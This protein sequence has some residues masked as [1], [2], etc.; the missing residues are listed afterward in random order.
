MRRY[1]FNKQLTYSLIFLLVVSLGDVFAQDKRMSAGKGNRLFYKGEYEK[2]IEQYLGALPEISKPKKVKEVHFKIA[3]S[4]RLSNRIHLAEEY[5]MKV[6]DTAWEVEYESAAFHLAQAYKANGK[7]DEAAAQYK[8]Y[9]SLD[10]EEMQHIGRATAELK[11]FEALSSTPLVPNEYIEL[12]NCDSLNSEGTEYAPVVLRDS[13]GHYKLYITKS[14]EGEMYPATGHGFTSLFEL[15]LEDTVANTGTLKEVPLKIDV[16]A[17]FNLGT[18]TFTPDG[19]T[20]VFAR[21]GSG[22][23]RDKKLKEVNLYLC[24]WQDTAWSKPELLPFSTNETWESTPT[25]SGDGKTLY[26]ASN[27]EG[28]YGGIDLYRSKVNSKGE[29]SNPQNLGSKINTKGNEMFPWVSPNQELYF[30]SDGHPGL[31]GLDIFIATRDGRKTTV[32]NIGEKFN[33]TFDDFGL[34]YKEELSGY[35]ASNRP[36]GKGGDDIWFFQDKTP[37]KFDYFVNVG[38]RYSKDA[39]DKDGNVF[40]G[41]PILGANV[42]ILKKKPKIK[43]DS[44]EQKELKEQLVA[45]YKAAVQDSVL[46]TVAG[47]K[48][49][50]IVNNYRQSLGEEFKVMLEKKEAAPLATEYVN[51]VRDSLVMEYRKTV[52][53][54]LA[55]AYREEVVQ[56][57]DSVIREYAA[58]VEDSLSKPITPEEEFE[59]VG[60]MTTGKYG[61]TKI[62]M[63]PGEEYTFVLEKEGSLTKRV[64]Y[65]APELDSATVANLVENGQ[66]DTVYKEEYEMDQ[67]AVG[68]VITMGNN[69]Y[70]L[71]DIFYELDEHIFEEDSNQHLKKLV[72]FLQDN[73]RLIVEISSHCDNR[74][75]DMYNLILSQKRA[76]YV[77]K[78]LIEKGVA[79]ERLTARGYGE[80]DLRVQNA[81]TEEEHRANRR[82][83]IRVVEIVQQEEEGATDE[84]PLEGDAGQGDAGEATEGEQ[85]EG[86]EKEG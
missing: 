27:R 56:Q 9:I 48:E 70:N 47:E 6:K 62:K 53:D 24:T 65:K 69:A 67:V 61:M 7:Y 46:R 72:T 30:A 51:M 64:T 66:R 10:F 15:E 80:F 17:P 82:T 22:Y 60:M 58:V 34:I 63:N 54:S 23:K 25:F 81:Q 3:E 2:A 57:T 37:P 20:M 55:S 75:T 50:E 33:S 52:R 59:E 68:D 39:A 45:E 42:T 76:N 5:Y 13:S 31:G 73:D 18:V 84:Q 35:F 86:K 43:L 12:T 85:L 40:A 4:F 26:F 29:W 71:D 36:G 49:R 28:G 21:G 32:A 74:G 83:E 41:E 19:Q 16:E 1:Y 38:L 8:E 77:V 14:K 79:E 78:Y 44:L 11:N